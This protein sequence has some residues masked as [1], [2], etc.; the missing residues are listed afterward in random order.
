MH[1]FFV[2]QSYYFIVWYFA[3]F[4]ATTKSIHY[5]AG[6]CLFYTETFTLATYIVQLF[7]VARLL[8]WTST[9][10]FNGIHICI[11]KLDICD[12]IEYRTHI[13]EIMENVN[14][15]VGKIHIIARKLVFK[16]IFNIINEFC[17]VTYW[18]LWL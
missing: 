3:A 14:V 5:S 18:T 13:N 16:K 4:P 6:S 7:H 9:V 17:W 12:T 10:S 15:S 11:H 1:R 2:A 8:F